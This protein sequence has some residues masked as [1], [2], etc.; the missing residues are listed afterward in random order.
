MLQFIILVIFIYEVYNF[1]NKAPSNYN[2]SQ[3]IA[4]V[5]FWSLLTAI[6]TV[7]GFPL[8][9]FAEFCITIT[10]LVYKLILD[11]SDFLQHGIIITR[12]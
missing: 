9:A 4:Y 2:Y 7:F 3:K 11:L 10:N 1:H 8:Y 5:I 6:I 12:S